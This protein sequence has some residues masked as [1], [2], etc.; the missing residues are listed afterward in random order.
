[1]TDTFCCQFTTGSMKGK[2]RPLVTDGPVQVQDFRGITYHFRGIY[3]IH[4]YENWLKLETL[5]PKLPPHDS[6][7]VTKPN[8]VVGGSKPDREIDSLLDE[9][10]TRWSSASCVPPEKETLGS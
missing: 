10:L 4:L 2:H 6:G 5:G 7:K 1:M 9:K 3:I 8:E